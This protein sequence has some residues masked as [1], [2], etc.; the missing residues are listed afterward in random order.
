M[1]DRDGTA[2][3]E[4][5]SIKIREIRDYPCNPVVEILPLLLV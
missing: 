1:D 2:H 4:S 3:I 5:R